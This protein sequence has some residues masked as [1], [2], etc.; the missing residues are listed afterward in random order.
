MAGAGAEDQIG[1]PPGWVGRAE[2]EMRRAGHFSTVPRSAIIAAVGSQSCALTAD[3]LAHELRRSGRPV[4]T[5]TVYRTF[6]L[7]EDLGLL[8]RLDLGDGLARY[9]PAVPG[10]AHHHHHFVCA[11]CGKVVPFADAELERAIEA[12]AARFAERVEEHEV[13]FRGTCRGCRRSQAR[14]RN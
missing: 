3:E 9:E 8:Q 12:C 5:A 13:I 14:K 1:A 11:G 6:E 7:L 4:G 2:D 10:G